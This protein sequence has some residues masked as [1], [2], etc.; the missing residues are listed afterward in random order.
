MLRCRL[1]LSPKAKFRCKAMFAGRTEL[2]S[3]WMARSGTV[4][5]SLFDR[6]AALA[7]NGAVVWTKRQDEPWSD[8]PW[9]SLVS[10]GEVVVNDLSIYRDAYY[11]TRPIDR[12]PATGVRVA[13]DALFVMGDNVA[14]SEDSRTWRPHGVPRHLVIGVPIGGE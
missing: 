10:E 2:V 9:L 7:I 5:W 12:W 1:Q 13:V 14:V 8:P 3:P 6:Q 11:A 4:E